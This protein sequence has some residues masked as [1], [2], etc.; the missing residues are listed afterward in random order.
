MK[1]MVVAWKVL[2][3]GRVM[4]EHCLFLDYVGET[5]LLDYTDEIKIYRLNYGNWVV[6]YFLDYVVE[7]C[8]LKCT[9]D[10]LVMYFSWHH[11][12]K[13]PC[14]HGT[15]VQLRHG[16]RYRISSRGTWYPY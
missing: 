13:G 11:A 3:V 12:T 10:E 7:T 2:A 4:E 16:T 5:C 15:I 14:H 8:L 1:A 6:K 9:A